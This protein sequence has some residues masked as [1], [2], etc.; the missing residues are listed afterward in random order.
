LAH[1]EISGTKNVLKNQSEQFFASSDAKNF[2]REYNELLDKEDKVEKPKKEESEEEWELKKQK[3]LRNL[4]QKGY[5]L[6][7]ELDNENADIEMVVK[8]FDKLG[9]LDSEEEVAEQ[10]R[11]Y[12]PESCSGC[13]YKAFCEEHCDDLCQYCK[14]K[15]YSEDNGVHYENEKQLEM[16][17]GEENE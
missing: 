15:K 3:A 16:P 9:W 2:I 11:R 7:E 13:R 17:T 5:R 4:A 12:L 14:Y 6:A 8:V 1:P 10:P